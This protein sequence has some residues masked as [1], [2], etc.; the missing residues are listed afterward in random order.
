[1]RPFPK[2][3]HLL[4]NEF[5]QDKIPENIGTENIFIHDVHD[6]LPFEDN[7]FD[8]IYC[9]HVVE[10]LDYPVTLLREMSRVSKAGY[11]ETPSVRAE[12]CRGIDGNGTPWRGYNH[13]HWFVGNVDGNLELI[14]KHSVIE[15]YLDFDESANEDILV[16]Y[17]IYW[18][19]YYLWENEVSFSIN[20]HRA[21]SSDYMASI[22]DLANAG[23]RSAGEFGALVV[24]AEPK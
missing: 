6:P 1:V 7:Y 4:S 23:S 21:V 11:I 18:N 3:T 13:H 19:S 17:P 15:Y 5:Y 2:A 10:D 14:R 16:K 24:A 20:Y 12:I 8:F 22:L 9:R